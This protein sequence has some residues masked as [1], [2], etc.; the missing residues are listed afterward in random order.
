MITLFATI[1]LDE[2]VISGLKNVARAPDGS[3]RPGNYKPPS[4]P[5]ALALFDHRLRSRQ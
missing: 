5:E 2:S 1:E 4:S 3:T